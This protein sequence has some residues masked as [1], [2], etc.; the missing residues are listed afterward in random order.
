MAPSQA[1]ATLRVA[2]GRVTRQDGNSLPPRSPV[3]QLFKS[4]G[5]Q[6]PAFASHDYAFREPL[7]AQRYGHRAA[8][9]R[10]FGLSTA[11]MLGDDE[12]F[13]ED[14]DVHLF[15]APLPYQAR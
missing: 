12:I 11:A 15:A 6:E 10:S 14:R 13:G 5:L 7:F 2:H 8:P 1:I 3:M 4:H 9:R